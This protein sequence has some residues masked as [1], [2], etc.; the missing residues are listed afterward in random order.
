MAVES[1]LGD[2][3]VLSFMETERTVHTFIVPGP[4]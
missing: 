2:N 4:F 1:H 3:D